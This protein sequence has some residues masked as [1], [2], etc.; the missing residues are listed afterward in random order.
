[1][2]ILITGA[3]GF[4]GRALIKRLKREKNFN[5]FGLVRQK[6]CLDIDYAI[7]DLTSTDE[8]ED[9]FKRHR[10]DVIFH[11]AAVTE[12]DKIVNDKYRTLDINLNG[13]RNILQ[14]F[15][16]YCKDALF[17]YSSS[18][19]VYGNTNELPITEQALVR[20]INVLG[21]VK[22]ITEKIIDFYAVPYNK[23]VIMRI[24]NVYGIS[25]KSTFVI[26][27]IMNQLKEGKDI[28]L[29]NITDKRDYLNIEDL[30]EAFYKIILAKD[31][32]KTE[33]IINIGSG[34]ALSVRDILDE[35]EKCLNIK[36]NVRVDNSRFRNDEKQI[37]FCDNSYFKKLT[38]WEVKNSISTSIKNMCQEYGLTE[39]YSAV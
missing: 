7:V 14:S 27:V 8:V 16:K 10:F 37:E 20:P 36:I 39:K 19:K 24:F 31:N 13:T 17:I 32:L 25:Q 4:L 2:N 33:E 26:P 22:S 23:Y 21:K 1:M 5:I 34:T 28:T 15:N 9:I 6:C 38:G 35:F 30:T 12:H 29:G 18:G 3:N 11:F